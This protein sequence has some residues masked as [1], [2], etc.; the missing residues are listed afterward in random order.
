MLR[1]Q[2]MMLKSCHRSTL[3]DSYPKHEPDVFQSTHCLSLHGLAAMEPQLCTFHSRSRWVL[4]AFM[5]H[6]RR[7]HLWTY[8]KIMQGKIPFFL[9]LCAPWRQ[10][11]TNCMH[12]IPVFSQCPRIDPWEQS[13]LLGL[14]PFP[15]PALQQLLGWFICRPEMYIFL[16]WKAFSFS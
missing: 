13:Q 16:L 3:D 15:N 10:G 8:E 5:L 11:L 9:F 7:H 6:L 12:T 2:A 14:H 4:I 1:L